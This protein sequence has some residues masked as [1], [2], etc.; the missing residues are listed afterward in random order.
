M[1][2]SALAA[3]HTSALLTRVLLNQA[4]AEEILQETFVSVFRKI[5][6]YRGDAPF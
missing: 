6:Q 1:D 5:G 4:K 2:F 3:K